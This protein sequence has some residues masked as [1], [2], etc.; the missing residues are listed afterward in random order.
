MRVVHL[1]G[2]SNLRSVF[3]VIASIGRVPRGGRPRPAGLGP[4]LAL[5]AG[6]IALSRILQAANFV[7]P[8][9]GGIGTVLE[10]LAGGYAAAGHEVIQV[11][12]G[13][14][15][16]VDAMPW[17]C[18]ITVPG[19]PLPGTGYRV[20]RLASVTRLI[21]EFV[22]DR[23]EVHD[24]S[25][26]RGV[27][28]FA[29]RRGIPSVVVSHERLDRLLGQWLPAPIAEGRLPDWSNSGLAAGFDTV[30]CTTAWAAE[31]F[32]RLPAANVRRVP[33]GVDLTRFSP[34][35]VDPELHDQLAPH[36]G[37]LLVL[38][39]R[40][41]REKRPE[42]AVH[43]V[44]ELLNRGQ[45]VCL[46]IAGDGPL[47]KRLEREARGLPVTFLGHLSGSGEMA[48][49]LATADVVL[50]PGPVETFGLAALEA[51]ASGSPVVANASSAVRELLGPHGGVIADGSPGAFADATEHVLSRPVVRRR[52][53]A[54]QRAERYGWPA[55]VAG[56]LA[57]HRLLDEAAFVA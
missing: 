25:T 5:A 30:I 7:A 23:V 10:R 16:A 9:S 51:L 33:L 26:L 18:R 47:R 53:A 52:A 19:L 42:L 48:K 4:R 28:R 32:T 6:G 55:T 41:S 44:H 2:T 29:H 31:E 38:A 14:R 27:G 21:A 12:P 35:A 56:F 1:L 13:D 15:S 50:A 49:L 20:I 3:L 45:P 36:G 34:A 11:I 24:R 17:G 8:H 39:S 43:T 37:P 22:P 54:R 40:L 57:A 46:A